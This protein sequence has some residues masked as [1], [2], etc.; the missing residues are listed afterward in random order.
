VGWTGRELVAF[1]LHLPSKIAYHNA[2]PGNLRRGNI[3]VWEQSLADRLQGVPL[4]L[5]TRIET[6]SILYRT[7][8][9]FGA[10]L[11]AAALAFIAAIW[12]VRRAGSRRAA[13][14]PREPGAIEASVRGDA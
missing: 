9:L 10:T 4:E 11:A 12:L 8:W 14:Q 2:P 6:Q 1:R 7:L 5:E 3:L 13:V